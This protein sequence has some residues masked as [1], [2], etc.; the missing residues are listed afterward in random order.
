MSQ[1]DEHEGALS[2][3]VLAAKRRRV[4]ELLGSPK[5][6]SKMLAEL[7]H[8]RHWDPAAVVHLPAAQQTGP[9]VLAALQRLGAPAEAYVMSS[10]HSLDGRSCSLADA[11]R[12][13]VSSSTGTVISCIPGRLA[14]FEGEEPNDRLILRTTA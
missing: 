3:F 1:P 8:F 5:R 10:H 11:V 7:P 13:V 14:Y 2:L 9:H 12:D 6:R 4:A